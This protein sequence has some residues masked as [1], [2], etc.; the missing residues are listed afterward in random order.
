[1]CVKI[2]IEAQLLN[3][4]WLKV[5]FSYVGTAYT[6]EVGVNLG[7]RDGL[8]WN[9]LLRMLKWYLSFVLYGRIGGG[10]YIHNE[11]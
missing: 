6:L 4:K 8:T 3:T 7:M 2:L 11:N 9:W 10:S 1:M 5:I